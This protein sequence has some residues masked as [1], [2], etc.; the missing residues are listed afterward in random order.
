MW[1]RR[2]LVAYAVAL[3]AA[4]LLSAEYL[5]HFIHQVV[6]ADDN[7]TPQPSPTRINAIG[8]LVELVAIASQI[9]FIIWLYRAATLARRAGLPARRSTLWAWLGFLVPIVN[10]WFPYQ[11]ARDTVPAG[12]PARRTVRLWWT[13]WLLQGAG[14]II[15]VVISY[16]SRSG[17][18][19][20]ALVFCAVAGLAASYGCTTVNAVLAAHRRMLPSR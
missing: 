14:L 16:F 1:A 19:L 7:G 15:I 11:V 8:D 9:L 5:G 4:Y 12:D 10:F 13:C 6:L 18:L 2:G 20:T 3:I 17:A